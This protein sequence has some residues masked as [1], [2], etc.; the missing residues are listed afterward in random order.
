MFAL[1]FMGYIINGAAPEVHLSGPSMMIVGEFANEGA[2]NS[3]IAS[4]K[5]KESFVGVGEPGEFRYAL[6]CVPKGSA[7]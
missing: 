7:K 4:W 1:I 2:C 5:P 3:A 6:I